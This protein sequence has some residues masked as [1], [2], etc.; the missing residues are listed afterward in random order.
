VVVFV[1]HWQY[2]YDVMIRLHGIQFQIILIVHINSGR[3]DVAFELAIAFIIQVS[4]CWLVS[5]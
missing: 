1:A 3:H 2:Y 4:L 5:V